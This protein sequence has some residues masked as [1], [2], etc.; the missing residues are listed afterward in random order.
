M[1]DEF[2][3]SLRRDPPPQFA[4]RLKQK[5]QSQETRRSW[6][7][8]S[9]TL[10]LLIAGSV[11]A[12]GL[13]VF[14]KH[15]DEPPPVAQSH[16]QVAPPASTI[17][18]VPAPP[19]PATQIR[20]AA[21]PTIPDQPPQAEPTQS[22][23]VASVATSPLTDALVRSYLASR[24][25]PQTAEPRIQTL[26]ADAAFTALCA[27]G[28]DRQFDLIVTSRRIDQAEFTTCRNNGAGRIIESKLG[29]QALV[30]ASARHSAPVKLAVGDV[31]L[32][33]A[34]QIP[35]AADLSRIIANTNFTW[36][37]V[38]N[39]LAYRAISVFG[40]M[41][42]TPLRLLFEKLLLE[43]GCNAQRTIEALQFTAPDHHAEL[44][45][46]VRDDRLYSAVEQTSNLIPQSLWADPHGF[47]L[48]DY[49]FYL[50]NRSQLS[51]SAVEGPEPSL[52]TFA[53]GTY[54]LA[55]PIYL[56]AD[57]T[58]I[59]RT[60]E[61]FEQLQSLQRSRL[62]VPNRFGFVRLDEQ[63]T[64]RHWRLKP[65]LSVSDLVPQRSVPR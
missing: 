55:R 13:F 42:D 6:S 3:Q 18:E 57:E 62:S 24:Q 8:R 25:R 54:P 38:N 23:P 35:D 45:H 58:R 39:K 19:K 65:P 12:G 20:A 41:R 14:K 1:N 4:R 36:D 31:Y 33:V 30:L 17:S 46:T 2:L 32:A 21:A 40:P 63:E 9:R 16:A 29:Y 64:L 50:E 60:A 22:R 27:A 51:D 15:S 10:L 11:F 28:N 56:Y 59:G 49:P 37:Q 43:P 5:L 48:V 44:C 7:W 61:V 52:A 26:E 53:D 47:V 34:Q